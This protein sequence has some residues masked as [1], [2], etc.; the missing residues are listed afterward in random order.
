MPNEKQL[1]SHLHELLAYLGQRGVNTFLVTVQHGLLSDTS[2]AD[3]SASYIADN[4]IMLRYFEALGEVRQ[5]LS[6]FK[7]R[8]GCHERTIRQ[9]AITSS[10]V[11]VGPIL[12]QFRGVLTGVPELVAAPGQEHDAHG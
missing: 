6:V 2:Q 11:Q 9:M 10:G 3:I 8:I 12:R 7:K 4:V 1:S 5:A